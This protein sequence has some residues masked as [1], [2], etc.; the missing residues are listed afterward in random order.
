[1]RNQEVEREPNE[2]GEQC[3]AKADLDIAISPGDNNVEVGC[4]REGEVRQHPTHKLGYGSGDVK[5]QQR[6]EPEEEHH[7]CRRISYDSRRE[8]SLVWNDPL[9]IEAPHVGPDVGNGLAGVL[10]QVLR[11]VPIYCSRH[12]RGTLLKVVLPVL[13]GPTILGQLNSLKASTHNH[14]F[15]NRRCPATS[16]RERWGSKTTAVPSAPTQYAPVP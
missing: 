14:S 4:P 12:T 2:E 3:D 8:R 10:E 11:V 5:A 15:R 16:V 1:M 6:G 9:E 13:A 7:P